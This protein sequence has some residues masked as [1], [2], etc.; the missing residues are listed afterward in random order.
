MN[1]TQQYNKDLRKA[2]EMIIDLIED[3]FKYISKIEDRLTYLGGY[4]PTDGR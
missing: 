2:F 3:N 4:L 1:Q